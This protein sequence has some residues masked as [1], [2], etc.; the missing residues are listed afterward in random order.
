LDSLGYGWSHSYLSNLIV[1]YKSDPNLIKINDE[2]GR[3][4]FFSTQDQIHYDGLFSENTTI[5]FGNDEYLWKRHDGK[6]LVFNITGRLIRIVDSVGNQQIL[7]YDLNDRLET[8]TDEASGRI[9]TFTYNADSLL[10][11]I[12]GPVTTVVPDGIWASYGY[13]AGNLTTATYADG[14]GFVYQYADPYDL[15][16][17]TQKNDM[18]GN[19]LSTWSYDDQD[20]AVGNTTRDGKGVS[21]D[22]VSAI[23]VDVT[24]AYGVIRSYTIDE[25]IGDRKRITHSQGASGCSSCSDETIRVT[26]DTSSRIIEKEYV[27]GRI[28]SFE[29]FDSQN[30]ATTVRLASGTGDEQIVHFTYDEANYPHLRLQLSR[31]ETSTLDAGDGSRLKETIWDYDNDYNAIPN[32]NPTPLLSRL[33]EKGYTHDADGNVVPYESIATFH[34]NAPGQLLSVD[35][36]L[37]GSA[38]TTAYAY[39]PATS[40]LLS[41]TRPVSGS[42]AFSNYDPAGRPGR[43]IDANANSIDYAYDGRGRP[44]AMTRLWDG[45]VT[46][47]TYTVAG[48]PDTVTLPNGTTLTYTYEPV[49]GRLIGITDALGNAV[50]HGYD[51]QGNIIDTGYHLPGG[52]RTFWQRFDYQY[53][54]RPGK[55]WKQV[56]P[57]DSF[58]DYAYDAMANLNQVTDPAG[59]VTTYGH[60]LLNRVTSMVQ[61][62][63]I[64]TW[65]T[66]DGQGNLVLVT[67]PESHPTEY[68]VDDLGR[69]VKI[70]SPNSGTT[71][72]VFD[73]AGN[74]VSKIDA[75]SITS[76]YTYDDEYR[77]TGIHYPDTSQDVTYAY[78]QDVNGMGR[79]TTMTDPSGVFSYAFDAAGNLVEEE[80][81]IEGR[82]YTT[83]YA[84][85]ASNILTG[86]T[87]PNGRSVSYELDGAGRVSRVTTTFNGTTAVVAD[88]LAYLPFG[89]LTGYDNGSGMHVANAFDESYRPT[90]I[91]AG[92]NL[93]L[94]YTLDPIGNVTAITDAL[95][96]SLSQSFGY[97]DLYRLTSASG[98][99][100]SVG[101]T[102]DKVGNRLTR[103]ADGQTD[104]YQY[105]AGTSRLQ[106]IT[107]ANPKSFTFDAAG[108]MTGAGGNAYVYNQNSRLI[109][110]TNASGSL[111]DYVYSASGQRIKTTTANGTTIFHYDMAGNLIGE[112]TVG[113]DFIA[114]YIYLGSLRLAAVAATEADE[115]A[116]TV[117][118]S[119]GRTLSGINVYA[120]T[121]S[122]SYTGKSAVTDASGKAAFDPDDLVDGSYQF[123]A[124]YLT[125][126]Y[127]SE[128][129]SLPDTLSTGI[130]I[131]EEPV[132]VQVT[133][134]GFPKAGVKVYLFNEA[135]SYLGIVETTDENGNVSFILPADQGYRFRADLLG[136]QFMSEILT[137]TTGS[138]NAFTVATGGGTLAVSLETQ[139]QTP[140][141]GINLY[142]FSASGSYLGLSGQTDS[143]G[144]VAYAVPSGTY[145]VRADYMGYQFWTDE[146]TVTAD[147]LSPLVLGHRDVTI[148]V[149]RDL[150]GD[151]NTQAGIPAYL[152]TS[153]GSYLG[154]NTTTDELGQAVFNVPARDY[155]VR[156][157]FMSNQY[158]SEPFNHTDQ[159]ITIEE[160]TATVTV[161]GQGLPLTGVNVSAFTDTGDYLDLNSQT[162]SQGQTTFRLPEGDYNFR[163]DYLSSQYFSGNT[164]LIAHT[165]NPVGLSTG[166]GNLML[167]VEKSAGDPMAGLTCY[168]FSADDVYLG[169]NQV[170]SGDGTVNFNLADGSYRIRVD[171]LGY[172]YWTDDFSIPAT[173]AGNLVIAHQD[174]TVTVAGD[175]NGD[176]LMKENIPVYLF[177]PDGAYMNHTAA[178]DA[179]GQAVF[180][181]P[182]KAY[183]IRADYLGREYWSDSFTAADAAITIPEGIAAV[184]VTQ[185]ADLL[186]NAR[187]CVFSTTDAYLGLS[188]ATDADG[189]VAFR[190]PA[191]TYQFR[192][193][194]MNSQ[195]WATAAVAA[196]VT[197]DITLS[198]GGGS[199][200]LTVQKGSGAALADVPVYVF[201]TVGSYLGLM[202]NTDATGQ[203]SFDLADGDYRFRADYL[204]YQFWTVDYTVSN[205][206]ADVL[207]ITHQDVTVTVNERY[208]FDTTALEDIPV[209]IYTA[210]GAYMGRNATTDASGQV[211]FNLP[212]A[213]YQ[214]RADVLSSQT[215]SAVFNQADVSVD[216]A[217]GQS[218]LH[219]FAGGSDLYDVPVY[220][221]TEAGAYLG[222][223][224][225]TDS[226]GMAAFLIP[227][228]AYK[229]RVDYDGSQIWSDV[230][231]ILAGEESITDMDLD[232][233]LSDLT[234]N[235]NP[236]RV[237]GKPP[238]YA[239]EKPMLATFGTLTGLI[240]E[241]LAGQTTVDKLYFFINDHLGTPK[242]VTDETG[243][244]V[245]KADYQPFGDVDV[246]VNTIENN[247]RFAGQYYDEETGL[248]YNYHRYYDPKTGRYLTPDPIGLAGG[249]N[250]FAYVKNNPITYIDPEGLEIRVY[251]SDAFGISGLNHAFVY[252]TETG[253]GK[254]TAGS[255]WVTRGDGVG[256]LNSPYTVVPLPP[257]M[258]ESDFMKNILEAEGWNN[259]IWTPWANDCHS[260]LENSFDQTGVPYPG[261]P[262]GRIDIDDNIRNDVNNAIRQMNQLNNPQYLYRLFGGY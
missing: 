113:G 228:G 88:N 185:A 27:N 248:H 244:V 153:A 21:I 38:D 98:V 89:P 136:G 119:E 105:L 132:T 194:H 86:I 11:H 187:V 33:V 114:A 87:Y 155:K 240:P 203:V 24:D 55:L 103:T 156:A 180:N 147:I 58:F 210:G 16:N 83:A 213:D 253:R 223:V 158:W 137:V 149:D 209:Y 31:T 96:A 168:L 107:G 227:A 186:E 247:L 57:D 84:Y 220:L 250:L 246:M 4:V 179:A 206:L 43:I 82:L 191:G 28:D 234:L 75:N 69:T 239:P 73:A 138:A 64:T 181:L 192:A 110:A 139:D 221:F 154:I 135:G 225:R 188:A 66:Y 162:D 79:L 177:T 41:I 104:T 56:N 49:Y 53:P 122:G 230:V 91:T 120:F 197:T 97:D 204:G 13:S 208:G 217:H 160:G 207:T 141:E 170:I 224:E 30:N 115:I 77:L 129:I 142:L 71:L 198:T 61:P 62:G 130:V 189:R 237:D 201:N 2:S 163:A 140:L 195:F 6:L 222:R 5:V 112:S 232:L 161:T 100:G 255:S 215:W 171:Y 238:A 108:N 190:L 199:F 123:R 63:S 124:D 45:A 151:V 70:V 134:A 12:S 22:Y 256:D 127:W 46:S 146:I 145:K 59:K 242:V 94:S 95:D 131:A 148:T 74:P 262:N 205:A 92:T 52:A 214:V 47:F 235:P 219:V 157:D 90:G 80:R 144:E 164:T 3:G 14:S 39:D 76:T 72:Y 32:E 133:Q 249:I 29:N 93:D 184:T 167:T 226:A 231:N 216:I 37:A 236:V 101:Y 166:G 7:S 99:F 26:Y 229:L 36:P 102:Y 126:Q 111:G 218:A 17:L 150:D 20:R 183:Q 44:T 23:Q 15:H 106:E 173:S 159:T 9:L 233:L 54:D 109:R 261:A 117:T 165:D 121:E 34:Y 254:G 169:Q 211:V 196:D 48:N 128:I 25:S 116:V 257:E 259:W 260:D 67:D 212:P 172:Q 10:D 40:D 60:D 245:W 51:T 85:D 78:D 42:T 152:F 202:A 174:V 8:V 81:T 68:V 178:T 35:G 175:N 200:A 118:P 1:N 19:L 252:S 65:Y 243:A 241:S 176:V 182:T 193:D 50:A 125:D 258:S 251:S 18:A 143:S